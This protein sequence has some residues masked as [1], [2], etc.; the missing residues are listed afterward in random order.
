MTTQA[1]YTADE[2]VLLLQAPAL[3][4]LFI[5]QATPYQPNLV[6][7]QFIT[8]LTAIIETA[9]HWPDT[10]LIQAVVAAICTGQAPP[11]P[12]IRPSSLRVARQQMLRVCRELTAL[13]AQRAP[14]TEAEAFARWLVA[15]A[16]QVALV[17]AAPGLAG[18]RAGAHLVPVRHALDR[19]A[20]T[21]DLPTRANLPIDLSIHSSH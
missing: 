5:I 10:D 13:L 18:D 9:Q 16:Q 19:L 3:A 8:S 2:W 7:R 15:I 21:L 4:S 12:T 20:V 17:S 6:A 14:E 1:D 11:S